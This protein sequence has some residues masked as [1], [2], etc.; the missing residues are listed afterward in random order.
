M[1]VPSAASRLS[2]GAAGVNEICG[3]VSDAVEDAASSPEP[4][5]AARIVA[6]ATAASLLINVI[7]ATIIFLISGMKSLRCVRF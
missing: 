1:T 7:D 5:Q 6:T 2:F 3:V 4:P